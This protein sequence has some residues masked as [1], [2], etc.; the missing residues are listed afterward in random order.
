MK[1]WKD[2]SQISF[3]AWWYGV[4]YNH[5]LDRAHV[6]PITLAIKRDL[7]WLPITTF[8]NTSARS[9]QLHT[10]RI[11]EVPKPP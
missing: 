10:P 5:R 4:C 8:L 2:R 3:Q 6:Y 11:E 9:T 7:L 1:S